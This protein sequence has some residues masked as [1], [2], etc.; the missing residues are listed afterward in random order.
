MVAVQGYENTNAFSCA[1]AASSRK[2]KA[3]KKYYV[4]L[5]RFGSELIAL[6]E[7][8]DFACQRQSTFSQDV[9][10]WRAAP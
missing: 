6:V 4:S 2:K 5:D 10:R 9:M 3:N 8:L 7:E 1:E